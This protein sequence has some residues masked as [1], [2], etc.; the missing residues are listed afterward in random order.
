MP[1]PP[2]PWRPPPLNAVATPG[3]RVLPAV[4]TLTCLQPGFS[5]L[6]GSVALGQTP[7]TAAGDLLFANSAPP[8]ARLPIGGTTQVLGI[9]GGLP[10]WIQPAFS[11]LSGNATI[12]QGGTGQTTAAAAFNAL[13]PLTTEGDLPYYH[14]SSNA[15]LAIGGTNTFLTSNGT[16]PAWGSLTAAEFGSQTGN[17]FLAAPNGS[18]GNP[19][20]RTLAAA[21]LPAS[22]TSNT[23]GNA[24]TAAALATAP[25]LCPGSAFA[26]GI[27]TSGNA[28]CIGSQTA[29][30]IYGAPNGSSGAPT[31]RALVGSDLPTIALSGGGTG[32][33]TAS[34]AF[35]TLSPLSTEGDLLYYNSSANNRLGVGGN[36][37]CLTSNGADPVWGSCSGSSN[38]AWSGLVNP[39]SNLTLSMST[40]ATTFNHTSVANWTWANT[41]AATSGTAQSSPLLNLSGAYWNGAASASDSWSLQN[42]VASGTNG[43]STLTLAHTGS[44]G[45]VALSVPNLTNTGTTQYGVLY[46]GGSSTAEK[47]T[48]AGA[49]GL[50]LLGQGSAA[51]AFGTLG[52]AGGGTGQT[53]ANAGL[54]ALSPLTTEGDL[55]YYHSSA[56]ARLARGS[57]NQCLDHEWQRS[58]LGFV[59]YGDRN[60][61]QRW[62]VDALH[63]L[64][65]RYP[66]VWIRHVDSDVGESK[67][68]PHSVRSQFG[69]CC[70]AHLPC[71]GGSRP[72]RSHGKYVGRS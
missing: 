36:G 46:G 11:S 18:S 6:A 33:T 58:R 59:Q 49:N 53:T 63:V 52:I 29:N 62:T 30:Y 27:A 68:S 7:L 61:Y 2:P 42:I 70:R 10:A 21:D 22:L 51:P 65:I 19:A 32:Q 37:Q 38:A 39:T 23:S 1:L 34:A 41:T 31:F 5:N 54:N 50:P 13:S 43:N 71:L 24:A 8:L 12:S 48:A 20:F 14:S 44:T 72:T 60:R 69:Q 67:R 3:L 9:S 57:N 47:S 4:E 55:L 15:R 16:D 66:G 17:T 45:T 26:L 56:N 28:N 35:S 25:S 40:Y 64:G